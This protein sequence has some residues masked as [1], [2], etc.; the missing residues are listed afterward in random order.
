MYEPPAPFPRQGLRPGSRAPNS[1]RVLEVLDD[2]LLVEERSIAG[3][4]WTELPMAVVP[5][6]PPPAGR[7]QGAI[8]EWAEGLANA[9]PAAW[10]Q[11]PAVDVLRRIPPRTRGRV[12]LA[13]LS[14]A[15]DYVG[16]VISSLRD[17]DDSFLAVQGPP[18][19]GKTYLAS[20]VIAELVGRRAWKIGV[21]AQ[22]HAVVENVL[23]AV[24][25][26]GLDPELVA[27]APKDPREPGEHGYTLI[28]KDG[29][30]DYTAAHAASGFVVGG[31]AWDFSNTDR[32][33][34]GSLDLLVI[35]EAGQFSL[36]STI[37][38]SVAARNLLLLGDPQQ[39]PQVSQGNHPEP[40]DTSALGWIADGH[41]VLPAEFG[42]FLAESRRMHPAVADPVSHLSYEGELHS[43]PVASLR[44][45]EGVA[46]GLTAVPIDHVGNTTASAEEALAVVEIVDSLIGRPWTEATDAAASALPRPLAQRDLIVVTPY[47]AQLTVVRAALD[48]AGFTDVPVGTVD[49]FQGQEAAVAI[50]SLAASSAA[51]APRGV[52]FLLLKNRLNVA[53]SRA[54]WSAFLLYSPGL[55]DSLPRTPEGVAQLSAFVRLVGG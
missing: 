21:V 28:A 39:L 41:D 47:N 45:L 46:P 43:H 35:D 8:L 22:S 6:T 17:L 14:A 54:K 48:A 40:I 2:G 1:V 10:P 26:A 3:C 20:R 19:T 31:T 29:V 12:P 44:L 34:R 30:A 33:P 24:V 36:A 9:Y 23:D 50:V 32:V 52:E 11:N 4:T 37:A 25:A 49:K 15:H 42:Y 55:L 51:A 27:K 53:I 5:G 7:Q 38:T 16:A 18:G 13:P